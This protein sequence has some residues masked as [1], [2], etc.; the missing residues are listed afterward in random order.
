MLETDPERVNA[1]YQKLKTFYRH[2]SESLH[3]GLGENISYAELYEMEN[4]TRCVLKKC[5]KFCKAELNANPSVTW[6]TVKEKIISEL[7]EK[8]ASEIEQGRFV[9]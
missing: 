1:L 5:L 3:E 2:R 9:D 6:Q 8:V 7:K 4:I